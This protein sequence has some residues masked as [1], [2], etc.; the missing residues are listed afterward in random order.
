[1]NCRTKSFLLSTIN[2]TCRSI[3][4]HSGYR[5]MIQYHAFVA[6]QIIGQICS[7]AGFIMAVLSVQSRHF[8]FAH[9]I[10]GLVVVILGLLQ[11]INA[12]L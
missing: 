1:M 2:H 3:R 6:L 9:G 12:V 8:G 7:I 10:L 11:P 5:R 4:L